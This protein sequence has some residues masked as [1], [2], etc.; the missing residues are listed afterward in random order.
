M[1]ITITEQ[2]FLATALLLFIS[3]LISKL[4]ARFGMP[5]LVIF[6]IIGMLAGSEGLGGI[7]FDDPDIAQFL[8]VLALSFILFSGGLSTKWSSVKPVIG[9]SIMLS[10]FGVFITAILVML[11]VYGFGHFSLKEGLLLG[12]IVSST[13]AAAVFAILRSKRMRMKQNIKAIIE[14]ESGSNDPMA[15]FLTISAIVFLAR[16]QMSVYELV[17]LFFSQMSVGALWG[18]LAGKL[19]PF[20][21]NRLNLE[22]EGFY[23]V[24]C[25]AM[26]L[27]SYGLV[28]LLGGN[29]FLAV[30]IAGLVMGNQ[31]FLHKTHLVRFHD[32]MASFMQ[33]SMFLVLGLLVFPSQLLSIAFLGT[34]ISLFLI[35]AARPIAVFFCLSF[36]GISFRE[37]I[38]I[39][40]TGL[41]GAVPIM[42]ATFPFLAKIPQANIIFNLVF[43][44][45]LISALFQGGLT[46]PMTRWLKVRN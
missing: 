28:T 14:F 2:I 40:W 23:D 7:E 22:N 31:H 19:L 6:L 35:F 4:A 42:L 8:G 43:F 34:S 27:F 11:F 3:I 1:F 39:A 32:G 29:G 24:L 13:D 15:V 26:V 30:Y 16:P 9:P 45:V 18:L 21:I 10:T 17:I 20:F 41:R 33:V 44:I 12:A 37:Q 38:M 36:F 5:A 25:M 46:L